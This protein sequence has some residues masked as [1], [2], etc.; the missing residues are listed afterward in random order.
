M[1]TCASKILFFTFRKIA[2]VTC[3]V[4]QLS[5]RSIDELIYLTGIIFNQCE[6]LNGLMNHYVPNYS[7]WVRHALFCI[8]KQWKTLNTNETFPIENSSLKVKANI[9]NQTLA[10]HLIWKLLHRHKYV[11]NSINQI[12]YI[13]IVTL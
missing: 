5:A 10:S 6:L 12:I 4:S 1:K 13:Y 7:K 11:R 9:A 3:I 8:W 2:A